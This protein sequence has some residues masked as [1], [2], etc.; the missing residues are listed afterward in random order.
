MA[1]RSLILGG[2][3]ALW[4]V[5]L[6][7]RLYQL[8]IFDYAELVGRAQRQQQRTIEVAPERG[9]IFDRQMHPLAMSLAVESVYAVPNGIHNRELVANLLAPGR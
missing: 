1:N 8:E 9:T 3:L 7:A 2:V 6:C 4:M 5:G